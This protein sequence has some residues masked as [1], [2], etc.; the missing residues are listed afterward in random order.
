M[1]NERGLKRFGILHGAAT[2]TNASREE[3]V[4]TAEDASTGL[5]TRTSPPWFIE[6]ML[7]TKFIHL[8]PSTLF[9]VII[10]RPPFLSW[11]KTT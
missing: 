2:V 5:R 3:S 9:Q 8:L 1:I 10:L 11:T 6:A 7:V 4:V